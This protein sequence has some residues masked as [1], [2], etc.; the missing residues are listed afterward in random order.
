[1]NTIGS[2]DIL[3]FIEN[4]KL[5][6]NVVNGVEDVYMDRLGNEHFPISKLVEK[7]IEEHLLTWP[8]PNPCSEEIKFV[9]SVQDL[10]CLPTPFRYKVYTLGYHTPADGGGR[11][12][13]YWDSSSILQENL[14]TVYGN[15]ICGRIILADTSNLTVKVFGARGDGVSYD[16]E[17]CQRA[18]NYFGTNGGEVIFP[19][20]VYAIEG[21]GLELGNLVNGFNGL[22]L[23]GSGQGTALKKVGAGNALL[24]IRGARC[25]VQ[26]LTFNGNSIAGSCVYLDTLFDGQPTTFKNCGFIHSIGQAIY[27]NDGD[28]Y[29]FDNCYFLS[30]GQWAYESRN[31]GMNSSMSECYIQG[32]GGLHFSSVTQQAEGF[33]I[34]NTTILATGGSG[35]GVDVEYGLEII[36]DNC[37]IDQTLVTGVVAR[38]N[39]S[40][41]KVLGSWV[42]GGTGG[43]VNISQNA[44]KITVSDTTLEGGTGSQIVANAS[45]VGNIHTLNLHGNIHNNINPSSQGMLIL[46]VSKASI[47]GC[48]VEG[49]SG[50]DSLYFSGGNKSVCTGNI[51]FKAPAVSSG[52]LMGVNVI[53]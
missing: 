43:C 40:L 10:L 32:S 19:P 30:C 52:I 47:V 26:D 20:G 42:A 16:R 5:I 38:N 48:Q 15:S 53:G 18:I 12:P 25:K 45:S 21:V 46:N 49:P 44:N 24:A 11:G 34:V 39:A 9:A 22:I 1:M 8:T 3:D 4:I 6:D 37:I 35:V 17:P 36:I 31:N 2:S 7:S 41:V 23:K 51:F 33:R 50:G 14:G 28:S 27:N 13:F 29:Q